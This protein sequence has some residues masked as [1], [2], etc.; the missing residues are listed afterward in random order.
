M[1]RNQH[2]PEKPGDDETKDLAKQL[3]LYADAITAFSAAQNAAFAYAA[4][5]GCEDGLAKVLIQMPSWLSVG[6]LIFAAAVYSAGLRLIYM[7][8]NKL[9]GPP[10]V[11]REE[12]RPV[13]SGIRLGRIGVIL[14]GMV[15]AV[16]TMS[17][18]LLKN[19]NHCPTPA[20]GAPPKT[21]EHPK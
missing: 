12:L 8:E 18:T 15:I 2:L 19:P 17:Y 20:P 1:K 14:F 13:L 5:K 6:S 16:G 11:R 3:T 10:K 4:I 9:I 21:A 7:G